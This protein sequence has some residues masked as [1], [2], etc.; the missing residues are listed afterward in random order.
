M[1]FYNDEGTENGGLI[2]SGEKKDGN[3]T[4]VGSL[5]FDQYEQ[6]Q[7]IALQYV[8]DSGKRRAGL[9]ITDYP[10]TI[11]GME[12]DEKRKALEEMPD[13]PEKTKAQD[14]LLQYSPKFRMYIGRGRDGHSL[15]MLADAQ[16]KPR[17]QL[18]V[19]ESGAARIEFLDE[20]GEVT[21]SLPDPTKEK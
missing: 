4:A 6:D 17:L 9:I 18:V 8:D 16:G 12:L 5:T 10:T 7:T 19:D 2:F 15:I 11:S 3:V 21:F 13:G 14:E 1:I 20:N